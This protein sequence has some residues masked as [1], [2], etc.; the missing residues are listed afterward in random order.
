MTSTQLRKLWHT[1]FASSLAAAAIFCAPLHA[2]DE[3]D[4]DGEETAAAAADTP[5]TWEEEKAEIEKFRKDTIDEYRAKIDRE[6]SERMVLS[7]ITANVRARRNVRGLGNFAL[8]RRSGIE[9]DWRNVTKAPA[10]SKDKIVTD[11]ENETRRQALDKFYSLDELEDFLPTRAEISAMSKREQKAMNEEERRKFALR[12]KTSAEA[13]AD[14]RFRLYKVGEKVDVLLRGGIGANAQIEQ[15]RYKGCDDER[16]L[17]GDRIIIRS[18]LTD[19]EQAHFYEEV[20][21]EVKERY[22]QSVVGRRESEMESYVTALQ[23]RLKPEQFLQCGYVPDIA[24]PTASLI[25]AK[26][27]F[28]MEK[29]ELYRRCRSY[30]INAKVKQFEAEKLPEIMRQRGYIEVPTTDGKSKEWITEAEKLRRENPAPN[31]P[32]PNMPVPQR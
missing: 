22:I 9:V 13:E 17:L 21:S 32:N 8:L 12:K 1:L 27:Q 26:P 14:E 25:T 11:I 4:E 15:A 24:Q 3:D 10:K 28:W 2:E 30:L 31:G 16:I 29:R 18:D 23:N 19:D 7:A 5:K 6:L 20:N